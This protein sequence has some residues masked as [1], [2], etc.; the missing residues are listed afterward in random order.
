MSRTLSH[1]ILG[2]LGRPLRADDRLSIT[3]SGDPVFVTPWRIAEAGA[4]ALGA[5]GLAASDLWRL[6][7]GRAQAVT[8]DRHAAAASLKSNTYVQIG[9]AHV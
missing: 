5:V 3:G 2:L 4:A 9:E 8:V 1:D 6:K 7:T